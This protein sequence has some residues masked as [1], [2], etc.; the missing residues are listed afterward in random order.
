MTRLARSSTTSRSSVQAPVERYFQ[1][2]SHTIMTTTPSSMRAAH[3]TAA[4][5]IAPDE[6]PANTPTSVMRRVHSMDSR[7]RTISLLSSSSNPSLSVN[8]GG[9]NPSSM[10]F[11]PSTSSPAGGSAAH[12]PTARVR[13][14]WEGPPRRAEAG[15]EVGDL[16]AVP[17]D[18]RARA[19]VV[20][21]RVGRVAVLVGEEPVGV[22]AGE[23]LGP[24]HGPV[25]ALR[26]RRPDDLGAPH[27][28]QLRALDRHVLGQHH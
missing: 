8:T 24:S 22:L 18:L 21:L 14:L 7:G 9:M 28:E 23:G 25:G 3:L 6:M 20:R 5:M 26:A 4:A 12:T 13:P 2:P 27:L 19:L 16:R 10:F 1:P 15:H 17:P 11:S